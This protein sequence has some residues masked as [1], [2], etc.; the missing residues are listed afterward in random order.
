VVAPA[1]LTEDFFD[2]FFEDFFDDF[3]LAPFLVEPLLVAMVF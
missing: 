2:D 3:L 1:P